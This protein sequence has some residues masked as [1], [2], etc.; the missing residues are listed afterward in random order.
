MKPLYLHPGKEKRV[1][2]GHRWIFSNEIASP[3]ND[4]EPGSWVEVYSSKKSLLGSGYINPK[5]LIAVRMVCPPGSGPTRD[6][7]Q[8]LLA[9]A[10][11]H[12]RE[13]LYPGADCYRAVF[14]ESDGIPG[15][16]VDRYGD[17]VC[18]Q[19]TTMGMA[20]IEPLMEELLMERFEPK[21]LIFRHD[22]QVRALEGLPIE[23]G[24]RAGALPDECRVR[25]DDIDFQLNPLTGQKT[26][27]YLDQRDNR[28]AL[29]RWAKGRKVLDLFCYNGAWSLAAA[30]GGAS[31]VVGVDQSSEAIGQ[32]RINAGLNG[33]EATCSFEETEVF[34][35]LRTVEK[36]A[37]D[38]I[39]LDPP[40][41]AKTKNA[42]PEAQKG[43]TDLNRRALLALKPGGILISCSC[44]YH[45][46]DELFRLVLT[47]ASQA[48][49]RQLRLI[50]A[51]GQ[52]L[53]HP[54]LLAMPESH[55]LKCYYLEVL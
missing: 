32:A 11:T 28:N 34:K 53:D 17:V 10:D 25:I 46:S 6:F 36:G 20:R 30:K 24:V 2:R 35:F 49:G 13:T 54:V 1:L 52:A 45:L 15:L 19:I 40:A 41:F 47:Q 8:G 18:Y 43:Y 37:F 50:E 16:I 5:S 4:F 22:A 21:A 44:S 29:G 12:R 39:V 42:L 38:V 51:R 14:G 33:V 27:F 26:G 55:Y 31:V 9:K 3:L 7:F 48:S 23:K